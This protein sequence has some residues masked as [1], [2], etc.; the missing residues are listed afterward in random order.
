M[1]ERAPAIERLDPLRPWFES[2]IAHSAA[3]KPG[4]RAVDKRDVVVAY[5]QRRLVFAC[6]A[7]VL[8]GGY[9]LLHHHGATTSTKS[10]SKVAQTAVAYAQAVVAFEHTYHRLPMLGTG[11]WPVP[12]EGP[13]VAGRPAM[14]DVPPLGTNLPVVQTVSRGGYQR[15]LGPTGYINYMTDARTYDLQK[16]AYVYEGYI[17]RVENHGLD[18]SSPLYCEAYGDPVA[19][20]CLSVG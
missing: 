13:V 9:Y 10:G 5:L 14:T 1:R 16:H 19:L 2:R 12:G 8:S 6:I 7:V 20:S 18:P 3:L 4:A 15:S 17:V 11:D